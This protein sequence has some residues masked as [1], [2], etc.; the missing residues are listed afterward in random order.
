MSYTSDHNPILLV[1]G[2]NN[3]FRDDTYIKKHIKRFEN[4]WI[5]DPDCSQIIKDTW[6]HTTGETHNKLKSIIN[7]TYHWGKGKVW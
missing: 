5:Q 2:T 4:A 3:D 6:L 1:F 7:N